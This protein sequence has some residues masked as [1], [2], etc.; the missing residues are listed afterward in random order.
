V[1]TGPDWDDERGEHPANATASTRNANSPL[2]VLALYVV[3][4]Q[5][6]TTLLAL[7]A[8]VCLIVWQQ[9][10]SPVYCGSVAISSSLVRL[11]TEVS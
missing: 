10:R 3:S 6:E 1:A 11:K 9:S 2:A 5:R 8:G 4:L 7:A